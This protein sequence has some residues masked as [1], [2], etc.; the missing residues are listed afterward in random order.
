MMKRFFTIIALSAFFFSLIPDLPAEARRGFGGGGF[1]RSSSLSGSMGRSGWGSSSRSSLGAECSFS[2]WGRS[3]RQATTTVPP[4]PNARP[5]GWTGGNMD[6]R[7]GTS[8]KIF[9]SR[10][11]AED[12]FR[13]DVK[14]KWDREPSARPE[15]VPNT[16]SSGGRNYDVVFN[17]G[18]Y[19]YWGPG[20]TWMALSAA[21]M[22]LN[23]GLLAN[24]GYYYGTP[25]YA[26]G[27]GGG[28]SGFFI[29][30]MIFV[31][32]AVAGSRARR[33]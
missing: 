8:G 18:G 16:Y 12:A 21:S 4:S 3:S 14:T 20:N 15:Y 26:G 28:S 5:S 33:F 13:R 23:A 22:L 24:H 17:N 27:G 10:S 32:V 25:H 29:V 6:K 31:F 9:N 2:S 30:L 19:G 11:E 1:G 7:I